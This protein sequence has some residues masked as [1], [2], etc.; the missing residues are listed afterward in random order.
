MRYLKDIVNETY[1]NSEGD[2]LYTELRPFLVSKEKVMLSFRDS[3]ITSSSF[4]NSSFGMLIEEF[5]LERFKNC[6]VPR[7]L[8][9]TQVAVLKKYVSSFEKNKA[10]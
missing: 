4:L 6:I 7:E 8:T 9:T 5:G 2:K 1:T 10:A 3:P